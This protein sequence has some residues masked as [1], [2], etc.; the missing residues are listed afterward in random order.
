[1]DTLA[2]L[3]ELVKAGKVREIGCRTSA[4]RS[5]AGA[6]RA[7]VR[8]VRSVQNEL[9]LL[10]RR[11]V[12][13]GPRG[14]WRILL[15]WRA[16]CSRASTGAVAAAGDRIAGWGGAAA[17]DRATF[18]VGL[19][20]S[21]SREHVVGAFAGSRPVVPR[22]RGAPRPGAHVGG[23]ETRAA[24]PAT[25]TGSEVGLSPLRCGGPR[26][27]SLFCTTTDRMPIL[28]SSMQRLSV[29]SLA[30]IAASLIVAGS[31]IAA[32]PSASSASGSGAAHPKVR[33]GSAGSSG[34][35]RSAGAPAPLAVGPTIPGIDVSHWQNTID[36][37]RVG[38]TTR[39]FVFVKATEGNDHRGPDV[40]HE[41]RR[42]HDERPP[43]GRLSLRPA[44]RVAG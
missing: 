2:T 17:V 5:C 23:V 6:T 21:R 28:R 43:G 9:N 3:D 11:D 27:S 10:D 35:A 15:R 34:D 40:R 39:R 12:D 1:M 44:R 24:R 16:A 37:T 4:P 33:R 30:L 13:D 8:R 41:P 42:S 22:C 7:R 14:G 36:W 29:P 32:S 18:D 38:A 25:A 31:L 20:T 19:A 26:R